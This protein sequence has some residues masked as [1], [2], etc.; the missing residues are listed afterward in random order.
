MKTF[1][2]VFCI[3]LGM[4]NFLNMDLEER[5]LIKNKLPIHPIRHH[6]IKFVVHQFLIEFFSNI[7]GSFKFFPIFIIQKLKGKES[8]E[9][10]V[11]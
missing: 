9:H 8:L 3:D 4:M 10:G 5:V 6:S 1:K 7:V 11:F 2:E